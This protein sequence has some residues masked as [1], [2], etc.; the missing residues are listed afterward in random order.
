VPYT[1]IGVASRIRLPENQR[2]N[3]NLLDRILCESIKSFV[4]YSPISILRKLY[5]I[6]DKRSVLQS[7]KK[8]IYQQVTIL[9]QSGIPS[10]T[11][12]LSVSLADN[13]LLFFFLFSYVQQLCQIFTFS[14]ILRFRRK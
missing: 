11:L 8:L 6:S 3:V 12:V 13:K 10:V 4:H 2:A 7:D 5:C 14:H 1:E 9:L